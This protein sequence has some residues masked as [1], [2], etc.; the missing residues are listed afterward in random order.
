MEFPTV[1][2][3]GL[4]QTHLCDIVGRNVVW[5][6]MVECTPI[7]ADA[8]LTSME[9]NC[10]LKCVAPPQLIQRSCSRCHSDSYQCSLVLFFNVCPANSLS[11]HPYPDAS[12][13]TRMKSLP[14]WL[15]VAIC[16]ISKKFNLADI[17]SLLSCLQ[18]FSI[19]GEKLF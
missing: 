19:C 3:H 6:W 18:N 15:I 14:G 11:S 10:K 12:R 1:Q 8:L 16:R 9:G 13:T 4:D 17:L 2:R 7:R 5:L